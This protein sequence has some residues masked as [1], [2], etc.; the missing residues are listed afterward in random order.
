MHERVA[1][2]CAVPCRAGTAVPAAEVLSAACIIPDRS[3]RPVDVGEQELSL[4]PTSAEIWLFCY[5]T[6]TRICCIMQITL[7]YKVI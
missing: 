2:I 6:K 3:T 7:R 1:R 5:L 4:T